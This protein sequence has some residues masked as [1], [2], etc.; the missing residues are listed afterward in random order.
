MTFVPHPRRSGN[1]HRW[2]LLSQQGALVPDSAECP[3]GHGTGPQGPVIRPGLAPDVS[4]T[5]GDL[6]P[7]PSSA[8]L[9]PLCL[10]PVPA[11]DNVLSEKQP[12]GGTWWLLA[13]FPPQTSPSLLGKIEG[14]RR[15]WGDSCWG[16]AQ[17]GLH[18][19]LCVSTAPSPSVLLRFLAR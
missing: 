9:P 15:P 19:G 16:R 17:P 2:A 10:P 4:G 6:V 13:P 3:A 18:R 7:A 1:A 8:S 5:K 11:G 14:R 12:G